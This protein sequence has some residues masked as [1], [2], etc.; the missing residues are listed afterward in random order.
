MDKKWTFN[1]RLS[2][3]LEGEPMT[4]AE[5]EEH[6][7]ARLNDPGEDAH[8]VRLN[9]V[10]FYGNTRH[11]AEAMRYAEEYLAESKDDNEITEMVFRQGQ[12]M[13]QAQDWEAAICYYSKALKFAAKVDVNR[14]LI[15]NN[16]GYSLNQLGRYAEAE[17]HLREAIRIDPGRANA[18]KNLGLSLQGQ[19]RY[20]EAA[21]NYIAAV[22][23]NAADPRALRHLEELAEQHKDLSAQ[24]PDLDHQILKCREAVEYVKKQ[25]PANPHRIH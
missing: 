16:I 3:P 12:L 11:I 6:L 1:F 9:L 17:P 5:A 4:F 23:A 8:S 10:S 25:Q 14:Y 21:E 22:R 15:H 20:A 13:E 19:G 2:R 18:F 7:L 24:I